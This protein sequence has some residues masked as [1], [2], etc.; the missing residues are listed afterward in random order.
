MCCVYPGLPEQN[1][2]APVSWKYLKPQFRLL[3]TKAKCR[4]RVRLFRT[5]FLSGGLP[6][7][8]FTE[9]LC[10]L[11]PEPCSAFR[12][13]ALCVT[14][15][16]WHFVFVAVEQE[17]RVESTPLCA[18]E[19][20][21]VKYRVRQWRLARWRST[22][23]YPVPVWC[24]LLSTSVSVVYEVFVYCWCQGSLLR[25]SALSMLLEVVDDGCR[26]LL[27]VQEHCGCMHIM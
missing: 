3:D 5:V 6:E 14:E 25:P 21:R 16:K 18:A 17:G 8:V 2:C 7:P 23:R 24:C 10:S 22:I 26:P 12:N 9:L 19:K 1:K 13:R 20:N 15:I 4:A 27:A 11:K